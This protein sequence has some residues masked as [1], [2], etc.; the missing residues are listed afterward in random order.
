MLPCRDGP[1]R[2]REAV[3]VEESADSYNG[4]VRT[5]LSSS[6]AQRVPGTAKISS[7]RTRRCSSRLARG[8]SSP[9]RWAVQWSRGLF[10]STST[11]CAEISPRERRDDGVSG[12]LLREPRAEIPLKVSGGHAEVVEALQLP[13]SIGGKRLDEGI[14]PAC[15]H[16]A[17]VALLIAGELR[18]VF[19]G[20]HSTAMRE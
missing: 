4:H 2:P 6:D 17:D 7:S 1:Y 10:R 11:S 3:L 5:D 19:R 13:G 18:K 12:T 8:Q 15:R 14:R 9:C 16:E 20:G